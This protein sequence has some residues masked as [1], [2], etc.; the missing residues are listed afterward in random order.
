MY[1][2]GIFDEPQIRTLLN[3]PQFVISMSP[4]GGRVWK[5]FG[6]VIKSFLGNRKSHNYKYIVKEFL[7]S[8]QFMGCNMS[9]KRHYFYNHMEKIA[10]NLGDFRSEQ[11]ESFH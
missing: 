5:A 2:A 8:F 9:V 11:G 3:D 10:E 1:K 7:S 6:S 4:I